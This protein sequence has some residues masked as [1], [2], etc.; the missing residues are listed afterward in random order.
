MREMNVWRTGLNDSPFAYWTN[1]EHEYQAKEMIICAVQYSCP[2]EKIGFRYENPT[3]IKKSGCEVMS[4][5]PLAI[6]EI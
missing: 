4:K 2:D 3:L 6:E 5:F 1:P